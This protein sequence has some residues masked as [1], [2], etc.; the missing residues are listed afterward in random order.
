MFLDFR[1]IFSGVIENYNRTLQFDLSDENFG[2]YSLIAPI[3]AQIM[4]KLCTS[5]VLLNLH[6][7]VNVEFQCARCTNDSKRS[8]VLNREFFVKNEEWCGDEGNFLPFSTDGVLD[9]KEFLYSEIILE[10]PTVLLCKDDCPGICQ[11][12]GKLKPCN[13]NSDEENS[14]D[15]RMLPL[16]QL[17]KD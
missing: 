14:V 1:K 2:A 16:L 10:I 9:L 17:L 7:E 5:A 6:C 13:C 12:C 4:A 8:Y 11:Y 3:D 15:E